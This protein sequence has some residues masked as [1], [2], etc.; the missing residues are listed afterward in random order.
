VGVRAE[1]RHGEHVVRLPSLA[2][3]AR[4][5]RYLAS[6]DFISASTRRTRTPSGTRP[7]ASWSTSGRLDT[8]S[9]G[10]CR[11]VRKQSAPLAPVGP[12]RTSLIELR[13][14]RFRPQSRCH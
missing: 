3:P 4:T 7:R 6:I 1:A 8:S 14:E 9:E 10:D 11:H 12:Q 5:P 2:P 13:R